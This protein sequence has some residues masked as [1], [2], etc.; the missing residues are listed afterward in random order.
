[1]EAG[2]VVGVVVLV[3][4]MGAALIARS[5]GLK[6]GLGQR[7]DP[8]ESQAL[9]CV[10]EGWELEVAS[11]KPTTAARSADD[12]LEDLGRVS[13]RLVAHPYDVLVRTDQD[14]R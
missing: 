7:I 11:G 3:M 10:Y 2:A 14:Q 12:L 5:F 9:R 6:V 8:N 4:S 1:M 13:R